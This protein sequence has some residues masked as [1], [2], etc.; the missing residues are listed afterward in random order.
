MPDTGVGCTSCRALLRPSTAESTA[1][2]WPVLIPEVSNEGG[3]ID[4]APW[5][6]VLSPMS[7]WDSVSCTDDASTLLDFLES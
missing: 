2:P 3:P 6:I 5:S 7:D 1:W 4:P